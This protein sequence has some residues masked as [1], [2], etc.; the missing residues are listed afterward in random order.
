MSAPFADAKFPEVWARVAYA[1]VV[2]TY[3][4]CKSD[5]LN[6]TQ[7]LGIA[8]DTLPA[9]LRDTIGTALLG[10][11][12]HVRQRRPSHAWR[13]TAILNSRAGCGFRRCFYDDYKAQRRRDP[14]VTNRGVTPIEAHLA[15]ISSV[16]STEKGDGTL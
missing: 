8:W 11:T 6:S 4:R 2:L 1:W 9:G 12:Y 15:S 7:C 13:A 3:K 5:Q 16:K 10:L 14:R